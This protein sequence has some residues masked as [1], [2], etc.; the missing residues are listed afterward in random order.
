MDQQVQAAWPD[1]LNTIARG[2]NP[3]YEA[4]FQVFP[5]EYYW[6][7]NQSEWATDIL[8]RDA[9]T[10][11]RLYPRLVHHGLLTFL[12]PDVMRFLGRNVPPTGNLRP[13]LQAEVISDLRT[14]P[15]GV[16]IK[17]RLRQN[18]IKMYDKHGSV[19]RIE[20][21][22]NDAMAFKTFRAPEGKPQAAPSWQRMRKGIADLHRCTQVSR[23][24]NDSYLRAIASVADTASL[25]ELAARL[26]QPAKR[27]GRRVRPLNPYA[28]A[29]AA[30]LEA[31]SRGELFRIRDL[32]SL[33]FADAAASIREQR[34]HAAAV[35]C[36]LLLLR[37][38]R[39]IR[40]VPH[41][42]R[43]HLTTAGRVAVTALITARNTSAEALTKLAA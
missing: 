1:L 9:A 39:L 5:V 7:T 24:A 2:L 11:A 6:S 17:H 34:R 22:I 29:D 20:T 28:P 19:L 35:P 13:R 15:E 31:I 41:T 40:K 21:T 12:S 30:L 3:R 27:N 36:K 33:L 16:R 43:Y 42:H 18:S 26:C 4:T 14:R 32:R 10:L 37:A 25:G 8:F 38:H 23:A